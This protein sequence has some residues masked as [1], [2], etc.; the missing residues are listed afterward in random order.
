MELRKLTD[1]FYQNNMHLVEV[2][3]KQK[4]CWTSH[5]TRGYGILICEYKRLTFGLPLRSR[6]MHPACFRTKGQAGLDYSKAVLITRPEYVAEVSFKIPF[7]E[8]KRIL[9]REMQIKKEFSKYIEHYRHGVL[10]KLSYISQDY[11]YSTLCN[12]HVELELI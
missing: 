3:D 5:K 1:V 7:E 9:T 12:Y 11:K 4:G 10:N 6:I 8:Y 2:L